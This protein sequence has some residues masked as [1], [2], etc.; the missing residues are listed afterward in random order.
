MAGKKKLKR[1]LSLPWFL[2][3]LS[4]VLNLSL[5]A[6]YFF[7]ILPYQ[8]SLNEKIDEFSRNETCTRT[9]SQSAGKVVCLSKE[10][11]KAESLS[12]CSEN[13]R[14]MLEDTDALKALRDIDD[15]EKLRDLSI[16]MCMQEKGYDY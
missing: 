12:E 1:K 5:L 14:Q 3:I 13:F 16:K 10:D 8:N 9:Y 2:F 4:L 7:K 6:T 11:L 15:L